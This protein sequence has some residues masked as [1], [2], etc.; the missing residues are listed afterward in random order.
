M[1]LRVI[2]TWKHFACDLGVC[3]RV[4]LHDRPLLTHTGVHVLMHARMHYWYP[5]HIDYYA[6]TYD[7]CAINLAHASALQTNN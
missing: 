2:H 4:Q 1:R 6:C 7:M 3:A 5:H